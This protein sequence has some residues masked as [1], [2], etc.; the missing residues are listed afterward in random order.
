MDNSESG[1]R[2]KKRDKKNF[3]SLLAYLKSWD[4]F[5]QPVGL[6]INGESEFKTL[7]GSIASIG[8]GIYMFCILMV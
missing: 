1:N 4:Q 6:S 7:Y 2:N 3:G 8:L 5:G